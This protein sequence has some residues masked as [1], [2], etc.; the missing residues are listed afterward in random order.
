MMEARAI[1]WLLAQLPLVMIILSPDEWWLWLRKGKPPVT[2]FK[3]MRN[4]WIF[5]LNE[6]NYP[7]ICVRPGFFYLAFR[8]GRPFRFWWKSKAYGLD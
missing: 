1:S 3:R 2:V 8:M 4:D 5:S 7:N 6:G